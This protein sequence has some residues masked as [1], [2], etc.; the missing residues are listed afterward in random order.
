MEW[1]GNRVMEWWRDGVVG[2]GIGRLGEW[3][4]AMFGAIW[5]VGAEL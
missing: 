1:W 2:E 4:M 5:G 3:R